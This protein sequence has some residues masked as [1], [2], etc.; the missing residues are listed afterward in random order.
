[1]VRTSMFS[2]SSQAKAVTR[3]VR[4][5]HL[6]RALCAFRQPERRWHPFAG[7]APTL[8]PLLI[9]IDMRLG[10]LDRSAARQSAETMPP[11]GFVT[12]VVRF[13]ARAAI[14]RRKK[15]K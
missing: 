4:E 5:V 7:G 1:M 14:S 3:R 2:G 9:S 13:C 12:V 8:Q 15:S 6:V 11:F 10:L